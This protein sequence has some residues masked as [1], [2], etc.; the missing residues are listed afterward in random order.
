MPLMFGEVL[1]VGGGDAGGFLPAML[2]RV[3]PEIGL[4]RGVGMV[5]DGDYAAL[6]VQLVEA[7]VF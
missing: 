3:E 7:G 1:A 2:Q 5:V 4:A 6:F